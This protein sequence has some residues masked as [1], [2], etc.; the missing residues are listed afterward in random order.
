MSY[1]RALAQRPVDCLSICLHLL[2]TET[3]P[4]EVTSFRVVHVGVVIGIEMWQ[5]S[6]EE[7]TV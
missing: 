6:S 2:E 7:E 5:R 3:V 4:A 1:Q